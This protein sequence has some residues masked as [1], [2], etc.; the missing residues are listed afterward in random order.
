MLL[1]EESSDKFPRLT[2]RSETPNRSLR[3]IHF[4]GNDLK[5]LGFL[6]FAKK[7]IFGV[8]SASM[9]REVLF[10][11]LHLVVGDRNLEQQN[12]LDG[13]QSPD[14]SLKPP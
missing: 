5:S 8:H 10:D 9:R 2:L 11:L 7:N 14:G 13:L 12:A 4:R 6:I 1:A 3:V